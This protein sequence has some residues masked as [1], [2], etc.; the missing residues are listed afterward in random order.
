MFNR[1]KDS[2]DHNAAMLNTTY[3]KIGVGIYS[4]YGITQ[5]GNYKVDFYGIQLFSM[6]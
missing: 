2:P 1:W 4:Q 6:N 3:K 5:N